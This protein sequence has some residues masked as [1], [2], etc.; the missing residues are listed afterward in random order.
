MSPQARILPGLALMLFTL[1]AILFLAVRLPTTGLDW[2]VSSVGELQLRLSA[3][4]PWQRV[5]AFRAGREPIPADP[6]LLMEEPDMLPDYASY[7]RLMHDM[8]LLSEAARRGTLAVRLADTEHYQPLAVRARHLG[9]LPG[10]FWYQVAFG[11][12]GCLIGLLVWAARPGRETILFALTGL[13]YLTFTTAAAVYSTRELLIDGYWWRLLSAINHGGALFFTASLTA[14]LWC[15][16]RRLGRVP[17]VTLSYLSAGLIWLIDQGQWLGTLAGF[18]LGVL[19]L[20]ALGI[21]FAVVQW[22]QSRHHPLDRATIRWFLLSIYLATGLFAGLIIIPSALNLPPPASQGVMFGAFLI[23]YV[24]MALGVIRYRLFELERWWFSI[25]AWLLGG[26]AVIVLDLL[27]IALLAVNEAIALTTA[28]AVVGWLWFP[29]RQWLW[30]RMMRRQGRSLVERLGDLL[31]EIAGLADE[32]A[33]Q[34]AWPGLLR[35]VYEPLTLAP[36]AG[37]LTAPALA[38]NGQTLCVPALGT[39]TQHYRLAHAGQGERLFT[40]EDT[41]HAR[42]LLHLLDL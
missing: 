39:D 36:H 35:R 34:N 23:M 14:L 28:V 18:H 8:D 7:N 13:G 4:D 15:Y 32:A 38:D 5:E 31:P 24:G 29:L 6:A 33:L 9:E 1:V 27:L 10:M 22:W 19:G 20:F 21:L 12:S 3:S 17:M 2:Q 40:A 16:P 42:V 26:L 37:A 41:R 30:Q 25:W 11:I